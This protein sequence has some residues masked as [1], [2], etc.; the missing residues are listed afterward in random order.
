MGAV[1]DTLTGRSIDTG[2]LDAASAMS[3]AT[4]LDAYKRGQDPKRMNIASIA[5]LLSSTVEGGTMP[6][7]V[8]PRMQNVNGGAVVGLGLRGT[9]LVLDQQS[10]ANKLAREDY[11]QGQALAQQQ[12]ET[13]ARQELAR[14]EMQ[15]RALSDAQRHKET[16]DYHDLVLKNAERQAALDET[17]AVQDAER[18]N[19][20]DVRVTND[21]YIIRTNPDGTV[22][23]TVDQT[24][25]NG[26][27]ADEARQAA[28]HGGGGGSGGTSSQGFY[29]VLGPNGEST[30]QYRQKGSTA[31]YIW[32]GKGFVSQSASGSRRSAAT[33]DVRMK[34][35]DKAIELEDKAAG[36]FKDPQDP[37]DTVA[38]A[39]VDAKRKTWINGHLAHYENILL[40]DVP[41]MPEDTGY[42]NSAPR[43]RTNAFTATPEQAAVQTTPDAP[44]ARPDL[45]TA[46]ST[47][48]SGTGPERP[49][50]KSA[51]DALIAGEEVQVQPK[52]AAPYVTPADAKEISPT[53]PPGY[54]LQYNSKTKETRLVPMTEQDKP[55]AER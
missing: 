17:K 23:T 51:I 7:P 12:R 25:R 22:E 1:I 52:K 29:E 34:L 32:D 42:F 43:L 11:R 13:A 38:K 37:T 39:E 41:E 4:A 8:E 30:G 24:I 3:Y 50:Q 14:Q 2:N 26:L 48:A 45:S 33:P 53:I 54:K 28:R 36:L 19:R 9:Q 10:Q 16:L 20:P 21:G 5:N 47:I 35:K 49:P 15:Q 55:N 40:G 18:L 6:A 27:L 46:E 44:P 31:L